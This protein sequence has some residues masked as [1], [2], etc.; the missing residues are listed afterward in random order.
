NMFGASPYYKWAKLHLGHRSINFS[1][2]IFSGRTFL[3]AG[4]ELTPG[5]WQFIAFSGTL[6]NYLSFQDIPVSGA[7]Q[8]PSFRRRILGA[9]VGIGS[10]HNRVESTAI[11]VKDQE[12]EQHDIPNQLN[13]VENLV[14]GSNFQFRIFKRVH[15]IVNGS[16]S[17]FTTDRTAE[18]II[19]QAPT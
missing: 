18:S 12:Q 8:L 4:I 14:I 6:R 9:T 11:T 13:P 10:R 19:G 2:Y 5:K 16:A 7:I 15:F 3:G 1:P 17:L